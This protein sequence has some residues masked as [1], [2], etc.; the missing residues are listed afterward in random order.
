MLRPEATLD[1][2]AQKWNVEIA[3]DRAMSRLQK[4]SSTVSKSGVRGIDGWKHD[5][6]DRQVSRI[7]EIAKAFGLGFYTGDD[8]A[9]LRG[10]AQRA[11]GRRYSPCRNGRAPQARRRFLRES[12]Q[13][14]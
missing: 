7:L 4:P 10:L 13:A 1:K 9:G 14:A 12:L 11:I 5:L 8:E 6:T 2:I 3:M